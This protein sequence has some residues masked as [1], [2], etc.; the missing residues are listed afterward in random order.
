M[1]SYFWT[2]LKFNLS[3]SLLNFKTFQKYPAVVPFFFILGRHPTGCVGAQERRGTLTACLQLS[4][5]LSGTHLTRP[6]RRRDGSG[7]GDSMS[8]GGALVSGA[9]LHLPTLGDTL[10]LAPLPIKGCAGTGLA[11]PCRATVAL[12]TACVSFE[13][14]RTH[15]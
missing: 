6:D 9:G 13:R 12:L 8:W 11:L 4:S 1:S 5:L 14:E 15:G 7:V 2:G 10:S 3:F